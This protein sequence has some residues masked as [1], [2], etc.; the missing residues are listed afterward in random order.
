VIHR[1]AVLAA[2]DEVMLDHDG[3]PLDLRHHLLRPEVEAS[4]VLNRPLSPPGSLELDMENIRLS[5]PSDRGCS[6]RRETTVQIYER[7]R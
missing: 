2:A 4:P 6:S 1:H 5:A 3:P 7:D